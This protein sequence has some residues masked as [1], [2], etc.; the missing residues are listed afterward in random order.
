MVDG[1]AV[2]SA[3]MTIVELIGHTS[4]DELG[5][6]LDSACRRRLTAPSVVD[7]RLVALG[8]RGRPGVEVFN[9]VMAGAGVESWLERQFVKLL[10]RL[11][12]PT[13]TRQR[14]Y[15][16]GTRT[17]ARVDFDFAPLNIVV[18]VGGRRGDMSAGE[19]RRQE[20]RRNE[21]QLG[22][23]VIFFFTTEDVRDD[24]DYVAASLLEAFGRRVA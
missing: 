23:K 20:H 4:E 13:P 8:R 5:N 9:R 1:L 21:L 22:G 11:P 16:K 19:R 18:E 6:A 7:R 14:I 24:P 17:I 10:D 15:R 2:T 3:T 12:L